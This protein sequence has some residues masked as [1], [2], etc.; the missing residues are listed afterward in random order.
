MGILDRLFRGKKKGKVGREKNSEEIAEKVA[1]SELEEL[2]VDNPKVYE[3]LK[4]TMFLD[5][6]K[7]AISMKDAVNKAKELEKAGD[8]LRAAVWYK[9]A[10]GLAIYEE[11][12]S[13]VKEY[14]GRYAKLTGRK[15]K[16]LEIVEEAV[17]KAQ[18]FYQKYLEEKK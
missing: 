2:C 13:K 15:L 6:T 16:I 18:E 17:K 9:I 1:L 12:T 10:G 4:D 8:F 3:A 7:I 11:D 14:F 5:P